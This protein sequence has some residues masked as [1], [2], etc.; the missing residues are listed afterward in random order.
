MSGGEWERRREHGSNLERLET[1][2]ELKKKTSTLITSLA[3]GFVDSRRKL[4][5]A[6]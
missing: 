1:A 2:S 3:D 4:L 5:D 6:L